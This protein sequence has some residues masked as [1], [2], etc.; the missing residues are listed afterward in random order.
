[1]QSTPDLV[2]TLIGDGIATAIV[3]GGTPPYSYKWSDP[4]GQF[5]PTAT[6]LLS[7]IYSVRVRDAHF[8]LMVDTVVVEETNSLP[9]ISGLT[10]VS[11]FPN[12]GT[13]VVYL[14]FGSPKPKI[15]TITVYDAFGKMQ[16]ELPVT[17][18][19]GHKTPVDLTGLKP[20]FYFLKLIA[21]GGSKVFKIEIV[22]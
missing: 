1:M 15:V 13:G 10:G 9:E 17:T 6:N 18:E 22:R 20:G 14:E 4:L 12:P 8:C 7:G 16:R 5:T 19:I 2:S 3:S 11:I 21:S